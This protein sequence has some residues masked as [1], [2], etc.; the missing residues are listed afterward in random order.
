MRR[1]QQ[2][3]GRRDS[4]ENDLL[5]NLSW[6]L[7]NLKGS[8]LSALFRGVNRGYCVRKGPSGKTCFE[9]VVKMGKKFL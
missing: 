9:T 7:T 8:S 6:A 5:T 3:I 4:I 2:I 1:R